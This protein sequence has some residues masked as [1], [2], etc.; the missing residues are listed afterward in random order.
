M[1]FRN[2]IYQLLAVLVITGSVVGIIVYVGLSDQLHED[3]LVR[4]VRYVSY[5]LDGPFRLDLI[6]IDTR[7]A[8]VGIVA[9]RSGGLVQTSAQMDDARLQGREVI[10]GIN[11]DFYSFQSTL[12]IG[13]Q[14]TDGQWVYGVSSRRS[15]VLVD[16]DGKVL[17]DAV[18]FTGSVVSADGSRA[19]ITGVNRHRANDQVM[20]YNTYFPAG[21]S[22]SDSTGVELAVEPMRGEQWL[23]GNPVRVRVIA[24]SDGYIHE[25]VTYV[26]SAG[27]EHT[28]FS[29]YNA[30]QPGDEL[31][32]MLGINDGAYSNITQIIGGGG[33]ILR[34]GSDATEENTPLEGIGEAFLQNRHPRTFVATSE[35]G[36]RIWLGTVDGRQVSSVGMN[37]PEMAS[38]LFQIGAWDA[39]NLDGG[40]STTMVVGSQV[41]NRPSDANGERAVSNILFVEQN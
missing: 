5:E 26:L 22:R 3:E 32:L 37:F 17:F 13:S 19:A 33:R 34:D 7:R 8:D 9:W 16:A 29:F 18:S 14:V 1:R 4:G 15:H 2:I 28:D 41:V 30:L 27:E 38:F 21:Q 39:V 10:A 6:E 12:P 35:D 36:G 24:R 40:G 25:A 11:A 31:T 20:F 23:A